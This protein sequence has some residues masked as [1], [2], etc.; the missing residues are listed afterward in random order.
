LRDT[1]SYAMETA[2]DAAETGDATVHFVVVARGRAI[3][4]DGPDELAAD[5]E[6]LE[7]VETWAQEDRGEADGPTVETA[8]VGLDR[9]LFS[10]GQYADTIL[11]YAA[12]HGADRIVLD[13]E[14]DPGGSAPM[15]RPLQV[16]LARSDVEIEEAAVERQTRRTVLARAETMKKAAVVFGVSFLFY[17]LLGSLSL[18]DVVTGAITAGIAALLL[19]PVAFGRQPSFRRLAL[20]LVRA[21]VYAPFLLWEITKANLSVAYVVLHPSLPIDPRMVELRAAV[22]GDTPVTTLANSITL[23][24]GTLTVD[25][26]QRSFTIHSLTASAR[27]DLFDGVLERAVRFVFYGRAAARIASPAERG[28]GEVVDD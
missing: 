1:V 28:D 18:F 4:P 27:D 11:E 20:Q 13:P 8:V 3:D 15:L 10:P 2:S 23:T 19:A 21:T 14:Y 6:L 25:V 9:Y 5:R 16:D 12:E 17:V 7:R 22:W 24:P 26:A